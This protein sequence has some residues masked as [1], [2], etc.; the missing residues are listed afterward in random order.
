MTKPDAPVVSQV[1]STTSMSWTDPTPVG[2]TPA[3]WGNLKNEIGFRLERAPVVSG[4]TGPYSVIT[5][6][7]ANQTSAQDTTAAGGTYKYRVVAFNTAG[8]TASNALSVTYPV[9]TLS[10]KITAGGAGLTPATVTI[11][12]AATGTVVATTTTTGTGANAG[13][14]S[15]SLL[16]GNY[17]MYIV[18]NLTGYA[19]QWYGG[20]NI[21]AATVINLTATTTLNVPLTGA[22]SYTL[23][24]TLTTTFGPAPNTRLVGANVAVYD[25]LT[26][27]ALKTVVSTAGGNY[28]VSLA[29]GSYKLKIMPNRI[30]YA[31]QWY[32]PG[33]TA[34]GNA[35]IINV[36]AAVTLNILVHV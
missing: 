18:P 20:A 26:G 9:Y 23:S 4:I 12:A 32:G 11:Y 27:S 31:N 5:T 35:Q 17:K 6:A 34:I 29:A 13:A 30:G 7:L 2:I 33:A 3:T 36:A 15:F 14:Y 1:G 8:E 19:T 28:T 16:A 24:G 25:A 21:G 10:G 22:A